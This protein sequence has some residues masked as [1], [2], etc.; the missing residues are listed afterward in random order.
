[1]GETDLRAH[2]GTA[3][4]AAASVAVSPAVASPWNRTNDA[5]FTSTTANYYRSNAPASAFTRIDSDTYFEY[6][7]TDNWMLSGR[8]S[9]GTSISDRTAGRITATGLN[10]AELS[11]QRQIQR[12]EHSATSFKI[13]GGRSGVLSADAQS[14]PPSANYEMEIR[15]LHGR[16]I[17]LS[18]LKIF[19]TAELGFR[20]RF[21]GDAEQVRA[22]TV[23]GIE[24]SRTWLLLI[25]AQ[26]ITSLGN[27]TPGFADFDL[28]KGQVSIVW[29]K[30][31]KFSI[32][33]GG[34]KEFA[35]RNLETGA[36]GFIGVWSEF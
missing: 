15:A 36:A 23:I 30:S 13:S 16:D 25:E 22:D 6:G 31:R 7:V 2:A 12:A 8:A 14:G 24:P 18:P 29:R 19:A 35:A 9:Y 27:E 21:G 10:E 26:T 33:L 28:Y 32:I 20:E 3:L 4:L 34:R 17:L 5:I 11:L 1:L